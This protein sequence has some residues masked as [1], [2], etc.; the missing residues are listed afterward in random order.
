MDR[1]PSKNRKRRG[2]SQDSI[3]PQVALKKMAD[4]LETIRTSMMRCA[5]CMKLKCGLLPEGR[6]IIGRDSPEEILL[7]RGYELSPLLQH[8]GYLT[9]APPFLEQFWREMALP[10]PIY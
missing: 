7:T 5:P 4:S 6:A 1:F 8:W 9:A 3:N 2:P 10:P